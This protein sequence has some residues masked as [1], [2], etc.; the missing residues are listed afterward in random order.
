[1]V[2][3]VGGESTRPGGKPV[4]AGEELRR[5]LPVIRAL[6]DDGDVLISIDTYKA[7]V[8]REAVIAGAH[9]VNDVS[10]LGDPE[11]AATCAGLGVPMVLMHMQGTPATMQISP[12][13]ADVVAEVTA[14]LVAR[15][16]IAVAAGVPSVLVDPGIGFG[17]NLTHNR[18]LLRSLP[19]EATWPTLV[20]VSRKRSVGEWSGEPDATLLDPGSIAAHLDAAR[21]GV[22][23]VRVHD[24]AGH[25]Q[26]LAVQSALLD[27]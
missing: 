26:A 3:D 19:V 18:D 12:S 25:V 13:Y 8:A 24:V 22:A 16:A 4:P 20:G 27:D 1:M 23:M 10:G 2:I 5:V 6:A 11:M 7:C 15:S 17:K 14:H 9:I 21:R